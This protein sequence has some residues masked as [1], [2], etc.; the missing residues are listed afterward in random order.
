MDL[1]MVFDGE[2]IPSMGFRPR[3]GFSGHALA[4]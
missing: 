4:A 1:G 3:Y 2:S